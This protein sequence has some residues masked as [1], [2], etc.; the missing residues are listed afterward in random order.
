[1]RVKGADILVEI[2]ETVLRYIAMKPTEAVIVALWIIASYVYREFP[3]FPRLRVRSPVKGCGKS[4][5]LDIIERLVNR[6]HKVDNASAPTLFRV[7]AL[8][9]PTQLLDEVDTW[10]RDD[11]DG[12]KRGIINAGHKKNGA[13][14][15]CVGD[16]QEVRSFPVFCPMVLTGIGKLAGT[17][18]D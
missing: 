7:I 9:H 8:I 13:V 5:L 17:I 18:E 14:D 3:I 4:T 6:P 12:E 10:L 15:R 2:I 11:K 1:E 16:N